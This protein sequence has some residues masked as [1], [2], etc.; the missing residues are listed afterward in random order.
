MSNDLSLS[1]EIGDDAAPVQNLDFPTPGGKGTGDTGNAVTNSTLLLPP[2]Q[3]S[4]FL[5]YV[6][7][8]LQ[9]VITGNDAAIN[10]GVTDFSRFP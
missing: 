7:K 3:D 10:Y 8:L 1:R 6:I 5:H 2:V 9:Y 4:R